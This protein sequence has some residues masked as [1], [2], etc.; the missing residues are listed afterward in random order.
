MEL[1]GIA[2]RELEMDGRLA[3]ARSGGRGRRAG[4]AAVPRDEPGASRPLTLSSSA[5]ADAVAVAESTI[6]TRSPTWA[7]ITDRSSG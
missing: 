5:S 1:V 2:G 3:H 7:A 4:S 6:A